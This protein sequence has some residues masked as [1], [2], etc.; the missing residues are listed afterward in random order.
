MLLKCQQ[1]V[2]HFVSCPSVLI[3]CSQ[4]SDRLHRKQYLINATPGVQIVLTS[5][6]ECQQYLESEMETYWLGGKNRTEIYS[7]VLL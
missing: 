5:D 6:G 4:G 2:S 1:K 3:P 7:E